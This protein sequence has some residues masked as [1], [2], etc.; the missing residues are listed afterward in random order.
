MA[1]IGGILTA[2]ALIAGGVMVGAHP[3]EPPAGSRV[4]IEVRDGFRYITA[5]GLPDHKTGQFPGRGNPN[6]I[7][8]QD[9]S[10]RVTVTPKAADKPVVIQPDGGRGG[11]PTLSGVALNGVVF[12]PGTAEF[13]KNDRSSGW[14]ITAIGPGPDLGIDQSHAHVQPNGAYHYHAV[15][16]GLLERLAGDELGKK[17][18]LVGWAADGFPIYARWGYDKAADA[19]SAVRILAPSYRVKAGERP[20]DGPPGKYDGTYEQ[21]YEFVPG[22]GD[23]DECNGR[24]GVTPE[25]P[26]GTYYY[27]ATDEYPNLPRMLKGAP[28][29]SFKKGPP[30]RG[31]RPGGRGGR[32]ARG[33]DRPPRDRPEPK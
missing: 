13:W 10:F 18:V 1:F 29:P 33:D 32:G 24:T 17:M 23:L 7:Q 19:K 30:G 21:D 6:S 11:P 28:D 14:H 31:N 4:K 22:L 20:K 26:E 16:T 2:A 3:D 25:F 5:N 9:Y 8:A 15:P 27:V 12:D